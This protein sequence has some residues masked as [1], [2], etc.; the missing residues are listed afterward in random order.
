MP[1]SP[2]GFPFGVFPS[3]GSRAFSRR[4]VA[5]L[6]LAYLR[7]LFPLPLR[8]ASV[9]AAPACLAFRAL[10]LPG[11]PLSHRLAVKPCGGPILPWFFSPSRAFPRSAMGR[12]SPLFLSWAWLVGSSRW[13]SL[14][15]SRVLLCRLVGLSFSG[16]PALMGSFHLVVPAI[17]LV[18]FR[19]RDYLFSSGCRVVSLPPA[20]PSLS[21]LCLRPEYNG[22]SCR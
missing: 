1:L 5:L 19:A 18:T 13:P 9:G 14:L 15:P 8:V 11:S 17:V 20:W 6:P 4:P 12:V 7:C 2:V 16:L 3:R 21:L 22:E 10:L